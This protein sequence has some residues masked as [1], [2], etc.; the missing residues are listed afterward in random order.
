METH[1]I[2]FYSLLCRLYLLFYD[3]VGIL[4]LIRTLLYLSGQ[5]KKNSLKFLSEVFF[6]NQI[7]NSIKSLIHLQSI[8]SKIHLHVDLQEIYPIEWDNV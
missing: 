3:E 1:F 5:K 7:R 2:N 6:F 8:N 4:F